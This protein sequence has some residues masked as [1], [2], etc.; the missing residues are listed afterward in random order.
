MNADEQLHYEARMNVP[1]AVI[2]ALAGILPV[3]AV[4][5][6]LGGPHAKVDEETLG[7][8][9][10]NK[11]V[12]RDILGTA[13]DGI[14][15]IALGFSLAY[16]FR[17]TVARNPEVKPGFVGAVAI[18]GGVVAAVSGVANAAVQGAKAHTFVSHGVQTYEQ[19]NHLLT[20]P[21]V[22]VPQLGVDLGL[23]L[24]AIAFVLVS[25]NAM[26]VG[27]L[28]RF[29]GYL[30]IFAGALVVF[31]IVPI[32]VV[33]GFWFLAVAVL[34]LGRWPS[35]QPPAWRSGRAEPWPSSREAA[36]QRARGGVQGR[37]S[38]GGRGKT[39]AT[40][41]PETVGAPARTRSA[42][43]KRKRKRRH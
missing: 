42:T 43:P 7:L 32:P 38:G 6:L 12:A 39:S 9:T 33:A 41:E 18:I 15:Y 40:P 36:D 4:A 21:A 11:R 34:L 8:I 27:L 1:E 29:I 3:L 25:L 20:S 16:L 10:A 19:A 35:G 37:G 23:L 17:I 31:P 30:G 22:L 26:R 13:I 14:G 28:T 5:I 2:A 24:T